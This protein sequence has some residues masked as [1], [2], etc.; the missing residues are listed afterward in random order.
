MRVA[1]LG[2]DTD[3]KV[4]YPYF[5]AHGHDVTICDQN[6]DVVLPEGA[7][8][9]LGQSYLEN[10][11]QFDLLVRTSGM[12]PHIITDANPSVADK[13]TTQIE[14]FLANAPTKNIIGVTGTK[15]KG[16]T[17]TLIAN[18]LE[19]AG[20]DVHIGGNIGI[21]PLSFIDELNEDSFVVLELSS[22][23]LMN[24]R[25]SPHIAVCLMVVPEHLNWHKDMDEYVW[26]KSQLFA[27]QTA[28]DVAIYAGFNEV[29]SRIAGTG[30]GQKI[31]FGTDDSEGAHV[32]DGAI[33]I[34]SVEI[35][36][37]SEL[38]LLGAHNQQ[39]ACAAVTAVWQAD[40]RDTVAITDVLKNFSGL[41]H[42]L[43]KVAFV[44]GVTYYDDSFGTT[45]ETAIVALEAFEEPKVI[46]L[47]GSDKGASYAALAEAVSRTNVRKVVLIGNQADRI[48][49]A[50]T[51]AG[52]TNT[53]TAGETM[54][55][56]V[57][58]A[59]GHAQAGDIVL[60]S[61]A[62]ASFDMFTDYKDRGNQFRAA[63]QAL[64][65]TV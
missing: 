41:P 19:A 49:E 39:N 48:Q 61:T 2:Y 10:L 31:A 30:N 57:A 32:K 21:P 43:E 9:Q 46:I 34:D 33:W 14:V 52:F 26:A 58:T 65:V 4:S 11:D 59:Q 3:G 23:Q 29:S 25:H 15:G 54:K 22:F 20:K 44:D 7:K 47:G 16:T 6:A 45:P 5:I 24:V 51:Q 60:L 28:E 62:C 12:P 37:T 36:K 18:M 55:D 1:L 50:L 17:S 13:I 27:N 53:V 56:I 35:C 38:A 42:R 40:V 63:A 8:A 64:E